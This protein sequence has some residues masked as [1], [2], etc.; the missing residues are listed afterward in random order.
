MALTENQ[1]QTLRTDLHQLATIE[2]SDVMAELLDHY[3]SL[4]EDRMATG[5]SFTEAS[6]WAW[7]DLG[8]GSGL[9]AIQTDFIK[10]T[11]RLMRQQHWTIVKSYF[12]WPILL[13]TILTGALLHLIV[14][15]I[16][17]QVL[18]LTTLAIGFTPAFIIRFTET[19]NSNGLASTSKIL[20]EY[21]RK[22]AIILMFA[23]NIWFNL[24]S[25][26]FGG[27][28]TRITFLETHAV[29]STVV[30]SL[31]LLYVASFSQ[32][33]YLH[34]R[35]QLFLAAVNTTKLFS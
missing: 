18:L 8:S 23:S 19:P 25:V 16:P 22:Q 7:A 3:A 13:T 34:F 9:Q 12:R 4:T 6:K 29:F 20:Q 32:L 28:D 2:Y 31:L 15:M 33:L 5:F 24:G 35:A 11:Q 10:T 21:L 27:T 30:L 26:L 17:A 14:P 1:L